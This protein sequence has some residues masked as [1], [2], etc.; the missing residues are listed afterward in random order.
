MWWA[1]AKSPPGEAGDLLVL[2]DFDYVRGRPVGGLT[3][4]G[5]G[6]EPAMPE[7]PDLQSGDPPLGQP[8]RDGPSGLSLHS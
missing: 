5:A 1:H 3:V 4:R 6:I 7:A 2:P 8:A